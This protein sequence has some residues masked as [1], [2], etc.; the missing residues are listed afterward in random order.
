MIQP[1]VLYGNNI[2][3]KQCNDISKDYN[4]KSLLSDMWETLQKSYG[5]G[6]AAPQ[7]NQSVRVFVIDTSGIIDDF[8]KDYSTKELPVKKVFINTCII[9]ESGEDFIFNE[10]CLSIPGISGKVRRKSSIRISYLDENFEQHEDTFTGV[11]ARVIQHEYDHIE[12]KLF[13]DYLS[14]LEKKLLKGKLGNI[15]KGNIKTQ[16]KTRN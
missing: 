16:Y 2:L 4:I 10:A 3:R 8:N 5:V 9:E 13:I 14:G 15:S 11:A 12:G 7:I 1:I 6:L